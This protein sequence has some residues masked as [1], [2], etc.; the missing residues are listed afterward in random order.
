[1]NSRSLDLERLAREQFERRSAR[2]QGSLAQRVYCRPTSRIVLDRLELPSGGRVLDVGCGTG[3]LLADIRDG[4]PGTRLFGLDL[5]EGMIHPSIFS[6]TC[7][8]VR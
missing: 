8:W 1:M 4:F 2:Y 6:I 5:C 7:F 3:Q